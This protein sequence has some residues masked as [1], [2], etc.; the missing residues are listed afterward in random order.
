MIQRKQSIWLLLAALLN[1]GVLF[2]DLF[3]V[4]T[5]AGATETIVPY[6]TNQHFPLLLI[7]IVMIALPMISIFL[8]RNR[9][10]QIRVSAFTIVAIGSFT[11]KML[12][13][14][15]VDPPA[16]ITYWIGAVLPIVAL[17]F[18]VM[19]ILGIR[20]D[21]KLVKSVDRLR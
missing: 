7:A 16:T 9:K 2:F 3:R 14:A 20:K 6:V 13:D 12:M 10:R 17:I 11:A 8:F 4:H 19:A 5:F 15:K 1:A 18:I 21:E